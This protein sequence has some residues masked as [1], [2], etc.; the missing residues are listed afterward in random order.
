MVQNLVEEHESK[1]TVNT[2]ADILK[3]NGIESVDLE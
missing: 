2:S 3:S 1:G